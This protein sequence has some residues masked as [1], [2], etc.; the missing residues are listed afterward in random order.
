MLGVPARL[1]SALRTL[2]IQQVCV[3]QIQ[4]GK[5]QTFI[6]VTSLFPA[7]GTL[8]CLLHAKAGAGVMHQ[9]RT[10]ARQ[11]GEAVRPGMAA[12]AHAPGSAWPGGRDSNPKP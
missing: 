11:L 2:A 9:Q 8:S 3:L 1:P 12:A 7:H 4:E 6:F 10:A 5:S